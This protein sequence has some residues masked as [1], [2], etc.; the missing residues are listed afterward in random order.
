MVLSI[1]RPLGSETTTPPGSSQRSV[2]GWAEYRRQADRSDRFTRWMLERTLSLLSLRLS[3]LPAERDVAYGV[4]MAIKHA[5]SQ[6]PVP[7][8][9]TATRS[10]LT[11]SRVDLLPLELT[12]SQ[13]SIVLAALEDTSKAE[14]DEL[15]AKRNNPW[16][17][18]RE[19]WLEHYN[20]VTGTELGKEAMAETQVKSEVAGSVWKVLVK[21]GDAVTSDQEL[22]IL[23]SM[24]MEIPVDAPCA[25]TVASVLVAPEDG[26]EEDQVLLII[27]S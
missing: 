3:L 5:L 10:E 19:A 7:R 16:G 1:F 27:A 17:G 25:G 21:E 23:E 26:V 6:P 14:L 4:E 2:T 22:M 20:Q 11:D 8:P 12:P 15:Q 13:T 9:Q 24:K 18:F